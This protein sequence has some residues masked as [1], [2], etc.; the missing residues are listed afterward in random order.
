MAEVQ[1]NE[2]GEGGKTKQ[3]KQ[4]LRVDFTPMVDMNMLLITFFMFCTTL[5]KPQTMNINMPMKD[6]NLTEEE[7]T[8]IKE[9]GAVTLL[10]GAN[11][12]LYYYLGIP[13]DQSTYADS[14]YLITSSYGAGG[15][16]SVLLEKNKGTYEKIQE[17][18]A[19]LKEGLIVDSVFRTKSKE[20]QE[21][22]KDYAPTVMIKPTELSTYKNMVDA[23]DEMLITNIGAY[24]I[25]DLTPGDRFFLYQRTGN[26]EYLTDEQ[27]VE[28]EQK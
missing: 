26:K 24:A 13:K 20:I 3:K 15:I 28:L 19:Q 10:L 2:K 5:L 11:D 6:E 18:K 12:E 7:K 8:K 27:R 25:I 21:G 14:T 23:L 1:Q 22:A 17:L 16:R 4:H 9:S